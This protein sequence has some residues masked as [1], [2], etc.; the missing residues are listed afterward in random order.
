MLALMF[1]GWISSNGRAELE[2]SEAFSIDSLQGDW[3]VESVNFADLTFSGI[4]K[5]PMKVAI[6]KDRISFQPGLGLSAQSSFNIGTDGFKSFRSINIV[7]LDQPQIMKLVFDQSQIP[8]HV[9][10][11]EKSKDKVIEMAGICRLDGKAVEICIALQAFPR[12]KEFK[13]SNSSVLFRIRRNEP[14]R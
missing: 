3:I 10:L 13:G 14:K 7:V 8:A 5:K 6:D 9:D 1:V 12:P 2:Q 11:V 4:G